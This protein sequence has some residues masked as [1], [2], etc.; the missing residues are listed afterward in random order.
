MNTCRF[1]DIIAAML[2]GAIVTG[3][4][5]T[6]WRSMTFSGQRVEVSLRCAT[7]PADLAAFAEK[8]SQHE[9]TLPA[10]LVADVHMA[11]A[12][13]LPD[14]ETI[15]MIEA[16]LLDDECQSQGHGPNRS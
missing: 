10:L 15:V 9:F 14:G 11:R 4:K 1:S 12:T 6:D 5:A 7:T 13:T 16:L 3:E 8:L 2:P